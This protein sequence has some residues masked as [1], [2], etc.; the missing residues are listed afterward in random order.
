MPVALRG[1]AVVYGTGL[2]LSSAL[3]SPAAGGRED[4]SRAGCWCIAAVQ[5][6]LPEPTRAE[7]MA[8]ARRD[9]GSGSGGAGPVPTGGRDIATMLP[10]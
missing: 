2:R 10:R 5:G 9:R 3:L 8:E 1:A 6:V 7:P 4:G